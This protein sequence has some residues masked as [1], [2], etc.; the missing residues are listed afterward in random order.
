MLTQYPVGISVYEWA[1]ENGHFHVKRE[2]EK[3]PAFIQKFS[4]AAQAH[5]HFERGSLE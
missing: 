2:K 5:F 3:S 1:I 4:S